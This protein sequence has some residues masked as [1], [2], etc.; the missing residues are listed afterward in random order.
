MNRLL[1]LMLLLVCV[2]GCSK[3][4]PD[5]L[6]AISQAGYNDVREAVPAKNPLKNITPADESTPVAHV[7]NRIKNDKFLGRFAIEV[8]P[9]EKGVKLTGKV[10]TKEHARRAGELAESTSGIDVVENELVVE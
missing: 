4:D 7:R 1:C 6:R 10:P 5:K 3:D 8:T 9:I 2:T